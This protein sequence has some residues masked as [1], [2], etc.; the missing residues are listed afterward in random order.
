VSTCRDPSKDV[1]S[2]KAE[3]S[4]GLRKKIQ[5][6]RKGE[7]YISGGHGAALSQWTGINFPIKPLEA[8]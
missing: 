2:E 6:L 8:R 1:P 7:R 3:A 4:P 5:E